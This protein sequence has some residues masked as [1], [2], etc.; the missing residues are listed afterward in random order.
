MT[1]NPFKNDALTSKFIG[2]P[3]EFEIPKNAEIKKAFVE[4][5]KRNFKKELSFACL[6]IFKRTT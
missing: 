4:I 6:Q 3:L 5:R 2:E 1:Q